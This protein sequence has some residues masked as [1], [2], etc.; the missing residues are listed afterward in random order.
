MTEH[1][2]HTAAISTAPVLIEQMLTLNILPAPTD[3]A[4]Y[5]RL[6]AGVTEAIKQTYPKGEV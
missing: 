4:G 3:K 5:M 6:L 1:E 2:L